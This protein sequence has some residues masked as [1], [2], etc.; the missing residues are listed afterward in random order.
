MARA[1]KV[2]SIQSSR[3]RRSRCTS[4]HEFRSTSS[5]TSAASIFGRR[6]Q[7][8]Y[9]IATTRLLCTNLDS[10]GQK[11]RCRITAL[12]VL[13][14]ICCR[15][16]K[17]IPRTRMQPAQ[18]SRRWLSR[19]TLPHGT[20]QCIAIR[21]VIGDECSGTNPALPRE[22]REHNASTS[23]ISTRLVIFPTPGVL[24]SGPCP[25]LH[26]SL[27]LSRKPGTLQYTLDPKSCSKSIH[28]AR[29]NGTHG[30]QARRLGLHHSLG[31]SS[32]TI[33]P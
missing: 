10:S 29:I 20:R 12:L 21:Y 9:G 16:R 15:P 18:P 14:S 31:C 5:G 22:K 2:T 8:S 27:S 1:D 33:P 32:P 6:E 25:L 28:H 23:S 3:H 13:S 24:A 7:S 11:A 4:Q 26:L 30:A 19:R 17:G